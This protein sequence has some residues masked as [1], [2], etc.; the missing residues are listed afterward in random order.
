MCW[1]SLVC[2]KERSPLVCID[3]III[4]FVLSTLIDSSLAWPNVFNTL[5]KYCISSYVYESN[6]TPSTCRSLIKVSSCM[7]FGPSTP[8]VVYFN[9]Y[10]TITFW[11]LSLFSKSHS[12]VQCFRLI[13]VVW[14]ILTL[15]VTEWFSFKCFGLKHAWPNVD[16]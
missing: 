3:F 13:L 16:L 14:T 7:S 8:F 9:I 12:L 6:T 15:T 5:S 2:N 10:P 4:I 11:S 1:F